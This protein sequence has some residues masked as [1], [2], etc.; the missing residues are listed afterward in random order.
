MMER[1]LQQFVIFA[2]CKGTHRPTSPEIVGV[3]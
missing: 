3:A 2:A 1:Y